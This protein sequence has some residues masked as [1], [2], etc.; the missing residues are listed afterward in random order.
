M[1]KT[2][3]LAGLIVVYV[4]MGMLVSP[5]EFFDFNS[6]VSF[7]YSVDKASEFRGLG[8]FILLCGL[9]ITHGAIFKKQLINVYLLSIAIYSSFSFGR[10][11]S[12]IIDGIPNQTISLILGVEIVILIACLINFSK[13]RKHTTV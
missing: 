11:V 13:Y 7:N 9:F 8:A 1:N 4:G 10:I 12:F 2:L 3:L 6:L 5:F